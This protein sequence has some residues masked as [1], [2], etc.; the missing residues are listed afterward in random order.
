MTRELMPSIL[1][2]EIDSQSNDAFGHSHFSL[3]LESLIEANDNHPPFSI[4][5]LGKW[6]SGKSSIKSIYLATLKDRGG[7][8][9][10][11][12]VT[13]NAW[14]YG[15]ENLKRA[16]LRHV[17]LEV[18][19]DR[20]ALNDALFNALQETV[21]KPLNWG[22]VWAEFYERVVW[23][24]IQL[25]IV[26]LVIAVAG[27][28]IAQAFSLDNPWT[29]ASV[30]GG[31][32]VLGWK[33][34][35]LLPKLNKT[36]LARTTPLVRIDAPRSS[37]EQFEELL[38]GQISNFKAGVVLKGKGKKCERLV[39]F[40]DDLDRL[41]AEE[42]VAGLDAIRTFM[43]IPIG[44]T[45]IGI[46]FVISCDEDR[47]AEALYRSKSTT[48]DMPGAV[49]NRS[50][51][52][53]YL[54]RIFQFR[55]E[56]PELP[57]RD[58]RAFATHRLKSD[59]P[60]II[61]DLQK[62]GVPLENV[63]DRMIHVGVES[64]RNCLQILNSFVQCWWIAKKREKIGPG[65][66]LAGGLQQGAV[67]NHPMALA[68]LSALR[69]DFPD[70]FHHLVKEPYLVERFT[71]V[72]VRGEPLNE[73]PESTRNILSHYAMSDGELLPQ[74]RQLKRFLSSLSG[75]R[76]P[77]SLLPLLQLSQDPI[78]RS[79]G[80]KAV[81]LYEAFVSDDSDE[82]LRILGREA[83]NRPLSVAEVRLLKDM[84]DDLE[85]ETPVRRDNAA[86]CIAQ[87]ANRL[88]EGEAH[89]LLSP[90]ARR[91]S[92]SPALR[93]R[94]GIPKIRNILPPLSSDDRRD[95]TDKIVADLLLI[96]GDTEFR[97]ESGQAPQLDDALQMVRDASELALWV[98]SVDG[99]TPATDEQLLR[100]LEIRRVG[101]DGREGS[102]S[103]TDLEKWVTE[104]D[105]TLL[106]SLKDRYTSLVIEQLEAEALDDLPVKAMLEKSKR[107]FDS[108]WEEGQ[109]S[110]FVL[111]QQLT[112]LASVR[113]E[114]AVQLAWSTMLEHP[115]APDDNDLSRF[116]TSLASRLQKDAE[117]DE[118]WPLDWETGGDALIS[119]VKNRQASLDTESQKELAGLVDAWSRHDIC[120]RHACEMINI[121]REIDSSEAATIVEN[122]IQRLLTDLP[123]DC[124][125]WI[126]THFSSDWTDHQRQQTVKRLT[127]L[128]NNENISEEEAQ[129]YELIM[130]SFTEDSLQS[131][132]LVSH[133]TNLCAQLRD[134]TSNPNQYVNKMFSVAAS[135][136]HLADSAVA[137]DMLQQLFTSIRGTRSLFRWAH[138]EMI[139]HWIQ[140]SASTATYA[141]IQ[142]FDEGLK[143]A[144]NSPRSEGTGKLLKSL[145]SIS[146]LNVEIPDALAKLA[147]ASCKVWPNDSDVVVE[148][149]GKIPFVPTAESVA[150]LIASVEVES[151]DDLKK[152]EDVWSL[153]A[154]KSDLNDCF[155]TAKAIL[156]RQPDNSS[157]YSDLGLKL[158][159][160]ANGDKQ[161]DVIAQTF[162]DELTDEQRRRLWLQVDERRNYLGHEFVLSLI[163]KV[164]GFEDSPQ[165]ANTVVDSQLRLAE[166]FS[167]K[168]EKYDL[169]KSLLNSYLSSDSI[170][171]KRRLLKWVKSLKVDEVLKDLPDLGGVTEEAL[172]LLKE[173]FPRSRHLKRM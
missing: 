69:V 32:T 169:G 144:N 52:R 108:L 2:R 15:G 173:E 50:D 3:A 55:L 139:G 23:P 151:E 51:A 166:L 54:D 124:V 72:F 147:D 172:D 110:R 67:T 77:D 88:P 1:D 73:Q 127:T 146:T 63:I 93:N 122:W 37:S 155:R 82:V 14:R 80:D 136:L 116:V 89:H 28:Y 86:A 97:L 6:G 41:S 101:V 17:Y 123:N 57:K 29:S 115:D 58:I 90:L 4:G 104:Y 141:P 159:L 62:Q 111:W 100:W 148:I 11:F 167:S 171:I 135:H 157:E 76:W 21:K 47:I 152:L 16:L 26:A 170:E 118:N 78:T 106:V 85:R 126:V 132:Q 12:P 134:R 163:P 133:V 161:A 81:P 131:P 83:D 87:L 103:F 112:Q 99:L 66:E 34:I 61:S 27:S 158:W 40:V 168:A 46:I 145:Y 22:E 71:G 38:I 142:L 125:D 49:F 20:G 53:R 156:Q 5:L 117:D 44:N 64:P 70:F 137:G 162:N 42:M 74:F 84:V 39:V 130:D 60:E 119:L 165:T 98:R 45:G 25:V 120:A 68:A 113:N 48:T 107:V 102:L 154:D 75:L 13:F 143:D 91:I 164:L 128:V 138:G 31:I 9:R 43:E 109:D 150:S 153:L 65:S 160:D 36:L 24:C 96:E 92:H 94:L 10:I 8:G 19:G 18:G 140:P 33:L 7:N 121:L 105:S 56:I 35:E 95:V 114:N 30:M 149:L 59:V 129:R 79:H